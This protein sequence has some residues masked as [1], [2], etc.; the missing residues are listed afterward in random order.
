MHKQ[1]ITSNA[2]IQSELRSYEAREDGRRTT[3]LVGQR[4][5][6]WKQGRAQQ[7]SA[8]RMLKKPFLITQLWEN[9]GSNDCYFARPQNSRDPRARANLVPELAR[10]IRQHERRGM[11]QG[12][13]GSSLGFPTICHAA[14]SLLK[15]LRRS[16]HTRHTLSSTLQSTATYNLGEKTLKQ[17]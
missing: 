15:I 17:I 9:H 4:P 11:H 16:E 3:M 8:A 2:C 6:K 7:V 12:N 1:I 13:S 5:K 14:T 10:L